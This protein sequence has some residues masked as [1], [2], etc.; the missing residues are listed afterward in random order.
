MDI[1]HLEDLPAGQAPQLM[2]C[3]P[4]QAAAS[5][6][7]QS[8]EWAAAP[9]GPAASLLPCSLAASRLRRQTTNVSQPPVTHHLVASR[10]K[11]GHSSLQRQ[12]AEPAMEQ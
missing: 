11:G 8:A 2:A 6:Q 5:S 9:A 1:R 7:S 4:S 10:I 3:Q 12:E